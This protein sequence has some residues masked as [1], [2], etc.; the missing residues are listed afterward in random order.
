MIFV[1]LQ[2]YLMGI[3]IESPLQLRRRIGALLSP[4]LGKWLQGLQVGAKESLQTLTN[5]QG[6]PPEQLV[7]FY[8][9]VSPWCDR[10]A[11]LYQLEC[12]LARIDYGT[13]YLKARKALV[14]LAAQEERCRYGV[15]QTSVGETPTV[16]TTFLGG[17]RCGLP[18]KP[19]TY[20][21]KKRNVLWEQPAL[22]GV[23]NSSTIAE[24]I[25]AR[26]LELLNDGLTRWKPL[27][28]ALIDS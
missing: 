8:Q 25:D 27:F 6:T 13:R 1:H 21:E 15:N 4:N 12:K 9:I 19:V 11:E 26:A 5:L 23:S 14:A 28:Q 20:W 7:V 2:V 3:T 17:D 22:L 18:T 24:V 10:N 16:D